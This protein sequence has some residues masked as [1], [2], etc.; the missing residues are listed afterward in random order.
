MK[1]GLL[2]QNKQL[3]V[4]GRSPVGEDIT[5]FWT[6]SGVRFITDATEVY[7]EIE[8]TYEK[9]DLWI[10]IMVDGEL[11]QR[12][13]LE[14]GENRICLLR[15]GELKRPRE[16]EILRVTQAFNEDECSVIK[17]KEIESNGKFFEVKEKPL[18]LE[19]IGDSITSGEGGA[20][21][22]EA[23]WFPAIFSCRDNYAYI[24]S[25]E[26]N[27]D[28][29]CIS[30]SGWGLY[31]AWDADYRHVIPPYYEKVA[32]TLKGEINA[33]AG[34]Q[35]KWDFG[36]RAVDAVVINLGTNDQSGLS[37]FKDEKDKKKYREG[38]QIAAISFLETIRRNNPQ[39]YI[40]WAY[41]MMGNDIEEDIREAIDKYIGKSGDKRVSLLML[42]KCEGDEIG[43]RVHPTFKG[44]LHAANILADDLRNKLGLTVRGI[45][46]VMRRAEKGD[47]L[48][49][50]FIGGSITQGS[51]ATTSENCYA[52][53]VFNWW[54]KKFP[55]A[56]FTYVNAGIGGTDSYYGVGRCE[57]DLLKENPDFVMVD[58]S[59]NDKENSF[60]Q[61]TYEGLI[62]RI[63]SCKSN[64]AVLAL[65]NVFYD[66]GASALEYHERVCKHYNIDGISMKD[67]LFEDIKNG[68]YER[69]DITP[70]NLH[71]SDKGHEEVARRITSYLE[72]VMDKTIN[73]SL[74][75][76]AVKK[77][78]DFA[79]LPYPLTYNRF[80]DTKRI[81]FNKEFSVA[82]EKFT[83]SFN[84]SH[85]GVQYRKTVKRPALI[86][87]MII[88][89][90]MLHPVI[91][92]GN[93]D[94]DWGDCIYLEH[95]FTDMGRNDHN[96]VIEIISG[97]DEDKIEKT[98]FLLYSFFI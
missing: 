10:E 34:A 57:E 82:G 18:L 33:L 58:F 38:F 2:Y 47:K 71:P 16:F 20:H 84:G 1:T 4:L 70:D 24:T 95:I 6:G 12:R 96:V 40:L 36:K 26:L 85:F 73:D 35:D 59:V 90:D 7:A 67:T 76:N 32:G 19:F 56:H 3:Q 11:S 98:P 54:E 52:K 22:R 87:R 92:D 37:F 61:E 72:A 65:Y 97:D 89:E 15:G 45:T 62:R 9:L 39:A 17:V 42:P 29:N 27:A 75:E 49:I 66:S 13:P 48:T 28:Y 60:Y 93:F 21:T 43:M 68:I 74:P 55:K 23:D 81:V 5:L 51:L 46:D 77:G 44:H 8:A 41:G 80:E 91:L 88:D 94:E 25:K 78:S 63:L 64:P 31:S 83:Y 53:R 86:A 30:Q 14:K 79:D 69:G 50:G